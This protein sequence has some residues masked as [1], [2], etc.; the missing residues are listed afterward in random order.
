MHIDKF[1]NED[2]C[3]VDQ[4]NGLEY[5]TAVEFILESPALFNFCGCGSPEDALEFLR[6]SLAHVKMRSDEAITFEAITQDELSVFGSQ[7]CAYFMYYVL[8]KAGLTDHGGCVPGWITK[9]GEELLEDLE[10][11]KAAEEPDGK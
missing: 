1:K 7:G 9:E 6:Q 10:E 5:E 2:G 8:D 3:Y 11:L 4:E